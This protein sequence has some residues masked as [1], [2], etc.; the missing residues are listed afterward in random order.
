MML[1]DIPEKNQRAMVALSGLVV[2][3][4]VF[5]ISSFDA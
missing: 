2:L 5:V 3:T 4:Y 1:A